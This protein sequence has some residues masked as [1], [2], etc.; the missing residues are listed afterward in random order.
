MSRGGK[1]DSTSTY[2]PRPD[3]T[4][5]VVRA[6]RR[7]RYASDFEAGGF[8]AIRFHP[9]GDVSD[10]SREQVTDVVASKRPGKKLKVSADAGMLYR[11]ANEIRVGDIV[12]TPGGGTRELLFGNVTGHYEYR[13]IPAVSNF[14]HVRRV[15][16]LGWCSRDELP[17]KVLDSLSPPRTIFKPKGQDSLL[18]LL[19]SLSAE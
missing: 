16:W 18:A 6:G 12:I 17:Q 9:V 2:N 7:G 10:M 8:V 15:E 13:E 19:R 11:F 1:L 5:W 14:R 4:F 3:A